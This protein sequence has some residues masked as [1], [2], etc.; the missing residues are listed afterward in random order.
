MLSKE[1]INEVFINSN[2]VENYNFLEEDLIKLA[3]AMIEKAR[4]KLVQAE[5]D[6]CIDIARAYNTLVADKIIEVRQ[7]K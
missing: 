7:G 4:P 5:R 1:E 6:A 2:L 3:N